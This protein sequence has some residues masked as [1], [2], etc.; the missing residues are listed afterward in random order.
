MERLWITE[1]ITPAV[2]SPSGEGD[3]SSASKADPDPALEIP[4]W[5]G[6]TVQASF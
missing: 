2:K 5:D 6:A 3:A 1:D 4:P